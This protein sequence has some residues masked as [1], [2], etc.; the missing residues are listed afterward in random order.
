MTRDL[1]AIGSSAGGVEALKRLVGALPDD[2]GATVLVGLHIPATGPTVLPQILQ[3]TTRL[4]VVPA[5]H[6]M[7]LRPGQVVV[8]QPD[9]HLLVEHDHVVLGRGGRENGHRPSHDAMLRS[10][11]LARGSRAVGVVLT[12]MLDDGAVGLACVERYGGLPLVQ[13]P[14]GADFPD[15]PRAALAAVPSAVPLPL[16]RLAAE[17]SVAV[18]DGRPLAVPD[19]AESQRAVDLAELASA[20]GEPGTLPDGSLPGVPSPFSCPDCRGVLRVVED[21]G[22]L[23]YRCRTGHAWTG[24]ALAGQQHHDVEEALWAALRTVDERA[25]LC[26]RLAADASSR[27]QS[28]SSSHWARRAEESERSAAVLRMLIQERAHPEEQPGATATYG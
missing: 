3:R 27:G 22:P 5:E 19:V 14:A 6:G 7:P 8:A 12:G 15:M 28:L 10:V 13:D 18:A 2:L 4:E 11:A 24:E 23:R 16:E 26:A 9:S 25:E 21:A 1:V 20:L 17:I